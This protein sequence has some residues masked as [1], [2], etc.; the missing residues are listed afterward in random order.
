MKPIQLEKLAKLI[1][2]EPFKDNIMA[3]E[4]IHGFLCAMVSNPIEVPNRT[5]MAAIVGNDKKL[6]AH[7]ATAEINAIATAMYDELEQAFASDKA[8]MPLI[9]AEGKVI[10]INDASIEQL[11]SWCAGYMAGVSANQQTWLSSGHNDIYGLLTPISAFAQFFDGNHPKDNDEAEIDPQTIRQQYLLLLPATVT[12]IYHFWRQ[13]QHCN[14]AHHHHHHE[15][16]R[17]ETPKVGRNDPCICGS[18][19]KSKKCCG[20]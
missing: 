18:G 2:A 3:I 13:H 5:W 15:T 14:H 19:K 12:N 7:E 4:Q 20:A 10:D 6:M 8:I 11:A 1:E 16:F 17:H 9:F